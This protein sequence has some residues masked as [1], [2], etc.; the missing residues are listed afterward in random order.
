M[1]RNNLL[2]Q[3]SGFDRPER[4]HKGIVIMMGSNMRWWSD[5]LEFACWNGDVIGLACLI[6][7]H[8][9]EIISWR[10]VAKP[11]IQ[12]VGCARRTDGSCGEQVR[13]T[14]DIGTGRG[15]SDNGSAYTA[16]IACIFAQQLGV[17]SFSN[18][19]KACNPKACH[20]LL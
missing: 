5:G 9:R 19:S 3:R 6:D 1:K 10:A 18:R 13:H 17:K 16:K 8:D 4:N 15:A 7:A 12:R 20:R 11:R 14:P 2:L